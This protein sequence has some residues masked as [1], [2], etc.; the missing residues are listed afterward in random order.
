MDIQSLA[1]ITGASSGI[2][3]EYA[4][5]LAQRGYSLLLVARRE[6]RLK[7]LK[8]ELETRYPKIE[9]HYLSQD[10]LV[11][12]ASE[13]VLRWVQ[14]HNWSVTLLVNNAGSGIYGY[15]QD[16]TLQEHHQTISLNVLSVIDLTHVFVKHMLSHGKPAFI[17]NIASLGGYIPVSQFSVYSGTKA[18]VIAFSEA[19][20]SEL[21]NTNIHVFTLSP[22]GVYTEFSQHANQDIKS[23]RGMMSPEA[24]VRFGLNKMFNRNRR[25]VPG[26]LNKLLLFVFQFLP[27][28]FAVDLSAKIMEGNVGKKV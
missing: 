21:K 3:E 14:D 24:V 12:D 20:A 27:T 13:Q 28:T 4:K 22:G 2:G 25:E 6:D 11:H 9:I 26:L 7:A 10:L 5:Q 17:C 19:L 23:S 8:Q 15:F 16:N 1:L 18:F